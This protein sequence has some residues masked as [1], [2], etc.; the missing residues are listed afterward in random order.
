MRYPTEYVN[1]PMGVADQCC[2]RATM[3]PGLE[4]HWLAL[5]ARP[6][7]RAAILEGVIV[8]IVR[9]AMV[10]VKGVII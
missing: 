2:G 6:D 3:Y 7:C 5:V 9:C 1:A 10:E 4:N 8:L